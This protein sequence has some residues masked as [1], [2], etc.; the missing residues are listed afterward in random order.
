MK[1]PA[2]TRAAA[3]NEPTRDAVTTRNQQRKPSRGPAPTTEFGRTLRD[4]L[5][6]TFKA[7]QVNE[8]ELFAAT[9]HQLILNRYGED[10]AEDFKSAFKLNMTDKP[11]AERFA[12]PERA[13]KESL[14][15]FVNSTLITREEARQIRQLAFTTAQLDSNLDFVWDSLGET[16]AVTSFAAGER[17]VQGRLEASGNAPI[18]ASRRGR[19]TAPSA[20]AGYATQA[21]PRP[22]RGRRTVKQSA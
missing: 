2:R 7:T 15:F 16:R 13:A 22:S 20:E 9:A 6:N 1:I 12:S 5:G 4:L 14:R 10:V 11:T 21:T 17:L 3:N 8:E 18:I 19:G